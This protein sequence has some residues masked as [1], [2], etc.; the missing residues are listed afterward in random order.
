M[1][2]GRA[3][4]EVPAEAERATTLA[5]DRVPP[6]WLL[7]SVRTRCLVAL[8]C[9][10]VGGVYP[11]AHELLY[12]P[13]V[14]ARSGRHEPRPCRCDVIF[15]RNATVATAAVSGGV[16]GGAL[17]GA[18][19]LNV[20]FG[21]GASAA[22]ANRVGMPWLTILAAVVPH[23]LFEIPAMV[24]ACA[25]GL[26]GTTAIVSLGIG[27]PV[28]W[29]SLVRQGTLCYVASLALLAVAAAV[30]CNVTPFILS[31]ALAR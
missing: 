27:R 10:V 13:R 9:M 30:E 4:G 16:T 17:T 6:A 25:A 31:G 26:I 8:A 14:P 24:A 23:V 7:L 22:R 2:E 15:L 29:R 5:S 19:A 12:G 20:G 21:I 1:S 3:I 11:I 18:A 28:P